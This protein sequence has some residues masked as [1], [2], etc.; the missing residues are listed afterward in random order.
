VKL[1]AFAAALGTG[2]WH[3]KLIAAAHGL[4]IASP[5]E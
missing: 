1:L 5:P 4:M 3:K 2:S